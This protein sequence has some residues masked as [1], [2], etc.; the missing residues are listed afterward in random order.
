MVVCRD[1]GVEGVPYGAELA[2]EVEEVFGADVVGE[3]LDEEC[4]ADELERFVGVSGSC[5]RGIP[6]HLRVE[7]A[8]IISA[9]SSVA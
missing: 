4:S 6:V 9:H 7:F 2:E 5:F 3:I 1:R 8:C